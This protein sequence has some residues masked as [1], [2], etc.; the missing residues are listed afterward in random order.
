MA[1]GIRGWWETGR[2]RG[3]GPWVLFADEGRAGGGNS[4]AA[5][6]LNPSRT[7]K[8]PQGGARN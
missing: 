7:P 5:A 6:M 4:P 8:G 3:N 1:A 2:G